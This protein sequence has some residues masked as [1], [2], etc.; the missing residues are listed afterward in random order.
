[1]ATLVSD[2]VSECLSLFGTLV[3]TRLVASIL[4]IDKGVKVMRKGNIDF[5]EYRISEKWPDLRTFL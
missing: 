2:S 5:C 4:L 3:S 1:M